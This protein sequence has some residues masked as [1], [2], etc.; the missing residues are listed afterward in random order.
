[1]G[2]IAARQHCC[3]IKNR[4]IVRRAWI[5]ADET[6][7]A[8]IVSKHGKV[9]DSCIEI[10]FAFRIRSN[11]ARVYLC[12][13]PFMA[14]PRSFQTVGEVEKDAVSA[15]HCVLYPTF[16]RLPLALIMRSAMFPSLVAANC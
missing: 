4:S 12:M 15:I 8:N 14:C 1:M 13:C 5:L 9:A 3:R 16:H 6:K 7:T 10:G 2:T 11:L